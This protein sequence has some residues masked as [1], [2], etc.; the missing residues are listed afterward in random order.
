MTLEYWK[1]SIRKIWESSF[2][3]ATIWIKNPFKS[4]SN[5]SL[6]FQV[7]NF[8]L[9]IDLFD[10]MTRLGHFQAWE[11]CWCHLF[12]TGLVQKYLTYFLSFFFTYI[13]TRKIKKRE[14][15]KRKEHQILSS[16]KLIFLLRTLSATILFSF[17]SK[18]V[19]LIEPYWKIVVK[20]LECY[21]K[22][23][24]LVFLFSFSF[25]HSVW[26]EKI[27]RLSDMWGYCLALKSNS[28]RFVLSS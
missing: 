17:H 10:E 20:H 22:W 7:D 11:T 6:I 27:T 14:W 2:L 25:I 16:F 4:S 28:V 15:R 24:S 23:G 18:V 5:I 12:Q 21:L 1:P 3:K 26:A 13:R 19:D 9:K 8:K